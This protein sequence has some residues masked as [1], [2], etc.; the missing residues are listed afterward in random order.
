[1]PKSQRFSAQCDNR[2]GV[3]RR[4]VEQHRYS[5][6]NFIGSMHQSRSDSMSY[7]RVITVIIA[8]I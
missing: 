7:R 6:Q 4:D 5:V 8:N 3:R 1:M 2:R